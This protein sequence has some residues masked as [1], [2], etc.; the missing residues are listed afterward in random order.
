MS[1][2]TDRNRVRGLGTAHEGAKHWWHQ[3]LT[4]IALVPLALLFLFPFARA[5]GHDH[6]TVLGLYRHTGHALV[7]VLFI[8]MA[9]LHL[10]Q[11]L[12][13]VIEDYVPGHATRTALL[14]CN[15]LFCGLF[16][17]AGIFAVA[18]IAFSG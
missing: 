13:V 15:T 2:Q 1:F 12:Q 11:G 4:S 6:A 18:K 10:A 3:R 16:A 5:L 8:A 9:F 17:V 14:I 7:A